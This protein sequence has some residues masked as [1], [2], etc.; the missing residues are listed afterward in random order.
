MIRFL[1][2]TSLLAP[3]L[4]LSACNTTL[5][6]SALLNLIR[7]ERQTELATDMRQHQF[8]LGQPVLVR[9]FKEE[10]LLEAWLGDEETGQYA[11]Y[12]TYPICKFSGT[13]GPKQREG[14]KQAP[15]GFYLVGA[16]QLNPN[17]QFHLAMNIGYPN[18]YDRA[19]GRTGSALMIHGGCASTGCFA[20]T[21]PAIEEVYLLVDNAMR[22]GQEYVNIH[23]FPFRM[24]PE[25]M[26]RHASSQWA[27]FWSNL[28]T[29]YDAFETNRVPPLV[30]VEN[31][32]YT[33][34]DRTLLTAAANAQTAQTASVSSGVSAGATSF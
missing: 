3:L 26:T 9:V 31:S 28:K 24:T 14:D 13:L 27:G 2:L 22:H 21:N 34:Y 20:M 6:S 33:F 18:A 5:P 4:F 19:Q 16:R 10:G 17:S 29:G 11:L 23:I 30:G 15:E 32:R 8:K 12:K 25:N 7:G 1:I